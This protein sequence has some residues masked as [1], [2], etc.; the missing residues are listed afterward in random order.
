MPVDNQIYDRL[1]HTWWDQD[2]A[3]VIMRTGLNAARFGYFKQILLERLDLR[4]EGLRALDV[5]CGG[6]YLAEEFARLGCRVTG[7]DPSER[8][9]DAA[10]AHARAVGLDIDYRSGSGE[11]IPFADGTFDIVYCCDVL[12]HVRDLD[13]VLAETA[14]V[15]RP[16]GV[17]LF[18]TINR[19]FR[20]WLVEIKVL[21]DWSL[22][23][24]QPRGLH[25]WRMF[26][27]PAELRAAMR[28]R[29]LEEQDLVGLQ[30]RVSPLRLLS[31]L[32][33]V[34]KGTVTYAEAGRRLDMGV[35]R[36][37]D[38]LYMGFAVRRPAGATAHLT[39]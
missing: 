23:R 32:R 2:G 16:G 22:T 29:G 14:R 28:R 25:D 18:D 37:M 8:S 24:V 35:S 36:N 17:Y 20:S 19:T 31:T 33:G 26:I 34:Q 15:L 7:V 13:R 38:E 39:G 12:E 6:G 9:L 5:G 1:A 21:Q 30:P 3:L 4:P 11:S 27:K 10:R